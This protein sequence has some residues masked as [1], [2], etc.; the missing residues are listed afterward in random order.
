ESDAT[1][2]IA[3][4]TNSVRDVFYADVS[5]SAP[6]TKLRASVT[7]AGNE[8]TGGISADA[9]IFVNGGQTLVAFESDKTDLSPSLAATTNVYLFNSTTRFTT[10]LNQALSTSLAAIGDGSARNP[11]IGQ[12][13]ANVAF[14][15]DATNIDVLRAD[16][17]GVTDVFLVDAAQA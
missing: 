11:V 2:L 6:F 16:G 4:D 5:G 1:D 17:N 8:G 3:A 12:D 13:G 14:E 15:S 9:S 7:A 10:L